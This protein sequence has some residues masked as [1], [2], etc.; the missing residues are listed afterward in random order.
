MNVDSF[1]TINATPEVKEAFIAATRGIVQITCAVDI[2]P[3]AIRWLWDGW[4]ARGKFHIFAVASTIRANAPKAR[5]PVTRSRGSLPAVPLEKC[6]IPNTAQPS[7]SPK[8]TS[9]CKA[10]RTSPFL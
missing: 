3:E 1:K 2:K 7:L 5:L 10:L 9:G 6:E 8:S 4:L